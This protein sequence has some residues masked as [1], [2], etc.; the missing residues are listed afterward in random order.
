MGDAAD[1]LDGA[2]DA[3][4]LHAETDGHSEKPRH[5]AR[6][7]AEEVPKQYR[8][9]PDDDDLK[10]SDIEIVEYPSSDEYDDDDDDSISYDDH[11]LLFDGG[12][13]DDD[14]GV[15]DGDKKPAAKDSIVDKKKKRRK[16][17][18]SNATI[19][20]AEQL[21]EHLEK[22]VE[23]QRG[24]TK[25]KD[26]ELIN[27]LVD[28]T[29]E[30]FEA[31]ND[32]VKIFVLQKGRRR[33]FK[34][35]GSTVDAVLRGFCEHVITS[36]P[37]VV[38]ERIVQHFEHLRAKGKLGAAHTLTVEE[39]IEPFA[40]YELNCKDGLPKLAE[41]GN[42]CTNYFIYAT[43]EAARSAAA[44]V[45]SSPNFNDA[46]ERNKATARALSEVVALLN[47]ISYIGE[48]LNPWPVRCQSNGFGGYKSNAVLHRLLTSGDFR[49]VA[50]NLDKAIQSAEVSDG[51]KKVRILSI[52]MMWHLLSTGMAV[53]GDRGSLCKVFGGGISV[54]GTAARMYRML[55][56]PTYL[57]ED[58]R[59]LLEW[60][61]IDVGG[62]QQHAVRVKSFGTTNDL[63]V[64]E[65]L[66][67]P[68]LHGWLAR[69]HF[70]AV[71]PPGLSLRD[72]I[73]NEDEDPAAQLT[74]RPHPWSDKKLSVRPLY[75]YNES[76]Q[77]GN[78]IGIYEIEQD[79]K[80]FSINPLCE[81]ID[82]QIFSAYLTSSLKSA[83]KR[84]L[85]LVVAYR[86]ANRVAVYIDID[87]GKQTAN[88]GR[89]LNNNSE[90]ESRDSNEGEESTASRV[91]R[92]KA[93]MMGKKR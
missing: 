87:I 89:M 65:A 39:R 44:G 2:D 41:N 57:P 83:W 81:N 61:E 1:S 34:G 52:E 64:R 29:K 71:F 24:R 46:S 73:E 28:I 40:K 16:K 30:A 14:D 55:E 9:D 92:M 62:K 59:G 79:N 35:D 42:S 17:K 82:E 76:F 91:A 32:E 19:K 13:D 15:D 33:G 5:S 38:A 68:R 27:R 36:Y 67:L 8:V 21:R 69:S 63:Q 10:D 48:T 86:L 88:L 72:I 25:K 3:S 66:K 23:Y 26:A 80:L 50:M 60:A 70:L 58:H 7:K 12:G 4:K 74:E 6:K 47:S 20:S 31:C 53:Q 85:D 18:K 43:P 11:L 37:V 56:H 75:Y 22:S 90:D 45:L 84:E 93:Y 78:A 51:L 54:S 49:V 77:P